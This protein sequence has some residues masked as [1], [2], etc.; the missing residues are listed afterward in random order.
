MKVMVWVGTAPPA[1]TVRWLD[2]A[3]AVAAKLPGAMTVAA[4]DRTWLDL[5]ADRATRAGLP[6]TGVLTDLQLDYLGW[7]QVVV[8][9]A[10]KLGADTI[11]VDEA[12]RPERF[13]EV[14]A[15]AELL[16]AAQLSHVVA[17]TAER[18]MLHASCAIGGQLRAVRA[19]GP[20]VIGVRIPGAEI[21]DYPTPTPSTTMERI[22]M[23]S[24][25][26]DQTAIGHRARAP[27]S[28][29]APRRNVERVAEQL[30]AHVQR[31]RT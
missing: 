7:A 23:V 13:P 22:D 11:I 3:L 8:T 18:T 27:H 14:A 2:G 28:A 31:G 10:K 30:A 29:Q 19:R 25:G 5:A 24:L 4:G 1:R 12:S 21:E 9:V 26:I 6:S 17:L 15:I 16:D 20:I